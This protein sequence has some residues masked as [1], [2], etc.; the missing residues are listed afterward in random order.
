MIIFDAAL[1]RIVRIGEKISIRTGIESGNVLNLT[2]FSFG[3]EYINFAAFGPNATPGQLQSLENFLVPSR[4]FKP[5]DLQIMLL[6]S[7]Q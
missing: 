1:S 5:R 7:F 3:A 6:I 4:T 2:G